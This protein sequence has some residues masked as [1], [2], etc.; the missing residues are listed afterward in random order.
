MKN[1]TKRFI[2]GITGSMGSGKSTATK[3]F[4]DLGAHPINADELA[5]KY[6]DM[7]SPIKNELVEIFGIEVLDEKEAP[8]RKL[9]ARVVFQDKEKLN[10]LTSLIHPRVRRDTLEIFDSMNEG[11]IV[12]W[13]AP[14]LFEA[15]GQKICDATLTV[16]TD[17]ES[18]FQRV[19]KRDGLSREEFDS[20][21]KNQMDIKEKINRSDFSIKNNGNLDYLQ[22]ECSKIYQFIIKNRG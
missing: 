21:I 6:T 22:S 1:W 14:L 5:K 2:L 10:R 17:L 19:Q 20:R 15:E 16:Y 3:I 4:A 9:I 12:A 7:N 11:R 13:E 8:D 18:A